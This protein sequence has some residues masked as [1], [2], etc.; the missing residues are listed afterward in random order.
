MEDWDVYCPFCKNRAVKPL[1]K[2]RKSR[3]KKK[4]PKTKHVNKIAVRK[5][6]EEVAKERKDSILIERSYWEQFHPK[7]VVSL[8]IR[9]HDAACA[10]CCTL[11]ELTFDH[12]V[13]L[14]KGGVNTLKNGQILC[15]TCNSV[16]GNLTISLPKL[17]LKVERYELRKKLISKYLYHEIN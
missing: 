2:R 1:I 4:T 12:V 11:S 5:T 9:G 10:C 17:R 6:P 16:K 13:P 8:I 7:R 14:S 15:K 3:K